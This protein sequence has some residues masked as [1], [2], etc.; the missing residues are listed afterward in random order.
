MDAELDDETGEIVVY[1][2]PLREPPVEGWG[3][4]IGDVV[5]NLR[6]A[7]DHLVWA[8]TLVNGHT[9]PA[10]IPP[11][12]Q[13]GSEWKD[14]RFPIYAFDFRKRYPS[15]RRIPWRF[16]PPN[17]LWGVRPALR[18]DLQR[19]QPFNHGKRAPKMPLAVLDELWNIDKHRHLH[20]V[21]YFVDLQNVFFADRPGINF[22]TLKT[23]APRPFKDR[24]QLGRVDD[25]FN[26]GSLRP[27]MPMQFQ[28]HFDIA[29]EQGPPA[30]GARVIQTLEDLRDTVTAIFVKFESEFA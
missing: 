23:E 3:A 7:L 15:G 8:L 19:L 18:A 25:P 12:P 11:K 10:V 28:L 5:H 27:D 20:L 21:Y 6:S 24:A 22:V 9:P 1:G 14:I 4:I 2:K 13:P 17:S 16:K 26:P 29:F 30:Y